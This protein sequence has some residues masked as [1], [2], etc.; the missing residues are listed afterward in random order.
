M[1]SLAKRVAEKREALGLSQSELARK[2]GV[3]PQA[4]QK[5]EAGETKK[6]RYIV[7]LASALQETPEFLQSGVR[8]STAREILPSP[9]ATIGEKVD[10]GGERIPVYGQAVGGVHG[11]FE[12]NGS[13]LYD[14]L[15]PPGLSRANGAY[16]VS[17]SGDSMSPRYEDADIAYV[18]P[19]RRVKRGDYVIAQIQCEEEG[20]ILAFVK[21]FISRNSE[22]LV[23]EQFNPAE[24]LTFPNDQVV[25]V[26]YIAM[27]GPST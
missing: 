14:V 16:A 8:K 18:D 2:I 11:E 24:R 10:A 5:V 12:L 13:M 19:T 3:T 25:S 21:R 1:S 17:I 15:S 27:S 6:P 26:H 23:L 7:E 9:N 4:I 20:P 22:T